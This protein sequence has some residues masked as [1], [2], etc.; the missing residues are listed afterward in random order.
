MRRLKPAATK[1]FG[2]KS[3][4]RKK[5]SSCFGSL[6]ARAFPPRISLAAM[7]QAPLEDLP[8]FSSEAAPSVERPP[9]APRL[10]GDTGLS[11]AIVAWGEALTAAGRSPH[12]VQ[13]FTAAL[14]LLAERLGWR[15]A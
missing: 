15:R 4:S 9:A 7:P 1:R 5:P 8:L 6:T 13:P 2:K 10:R 14:R 12:T 3:D 11:A